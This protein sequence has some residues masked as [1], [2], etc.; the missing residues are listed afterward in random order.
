MNIINWLLADYDK[1]Q[2]LADA[3]NWTPKMI[4]IHRTR[5]VTGLI[6]GFIIGLFTGLAL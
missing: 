3:K 4:Y 1:F 6:L 5:L 2:D